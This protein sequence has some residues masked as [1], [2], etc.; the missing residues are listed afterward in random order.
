[1]DHRYEDGRPINY[2]DMFFV[3]ERRSH[4]LNVFN[5][6]LDF[7]EELDLE[8]RV[9]R[10]EHHALALRHLQA[11]RYQSLPPRARRSLLHFIWM[12]DR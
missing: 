2:I 10:H 8:I 3:L 9:G 6:G 5:E 1:M 12:S 7:N 4:D 11:L